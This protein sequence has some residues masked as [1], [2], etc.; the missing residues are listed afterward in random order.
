MAFNLAWKNTGFVLHTNYEKLF[1]CSHSEAGVLHV[2]IGKVRLNL[3]EGA[4]KDSCFNSPKNRSR[5]AIKFLC[6]EGR[7]SSA[8]SCTL[9]LESSYI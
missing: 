5:K 4:F 2:K 7:I 6:K 9:N 1:N 3:G 8:A